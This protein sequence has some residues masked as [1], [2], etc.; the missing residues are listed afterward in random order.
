MAILFCTNA[1]LFEVK[2]DQILSKFR[3]HRPLVWRAATVFLTC[4]LI[5]TMISFFSP[6]VTFRMDPNYRLEF[7][8]ILC[9]VGGAG[10]FLC[11]LVLQFTFAKCPMLLKSMLQ[12]ICGTIAVLIP[13]FLIYDP[14]ELP[15]YRTSAVFVWT[16]MV[17]IVAGAFILGQ[18]LKGPADMTSR[19]SPPPAP[20]SK[21]KILSRLP[22]HLQDAELYA[23][24]AEDH[25]VRVHTSKGDDILLMRLSDS[26]AETSGV[27]GSQT[28]RSW[29]VA[30]NAV[31]HLK[32]LGR[33]AQIE[34]PNGLLAPV[35]RNG[36]KTLKD[37]GWL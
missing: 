14:Y 16:V 23:L 13:L 18:M 37:L 32:K 27:D 24:S 19:V 11:D 4:L 28:H 6:S 30:K 26:I 3:T 15:G 12:T 7:W 8:V 36:L 22:V 34:L 25:Y 31:D 1:V 2:M 33:T 20:S 10:I 35:S 29:W 17:L 21:P 9:L 5:G